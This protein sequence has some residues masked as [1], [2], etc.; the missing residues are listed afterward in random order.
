MVDMMTDSRGLEEARRWLLELGNQ[1]MI[2]GIE[3]DEN[4]RK[5]VELLVCTWRD[6]IY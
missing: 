3:M 5:L 4:Q 2:G 1:R 6:R